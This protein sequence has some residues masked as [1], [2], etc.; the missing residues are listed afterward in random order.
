[1]GKHQEEKSEI[2]PS[3]DEAESR[4]GHR[5]KKETQQAEILT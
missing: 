4:T 3:S 2:K 1:M 5:A